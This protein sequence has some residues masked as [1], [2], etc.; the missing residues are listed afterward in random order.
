MLFFLWLPSADL[1]VT[2][3][4]NRVRQGGHNIAEPDIRRRF[5]TGFRNLFGLYRVLVDRW[6]LYDASHYPARLIAQEEGGKVQVAE[7]ALY[8]QIMIAAER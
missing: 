5:S 2:R 7:A 8:N 1:A 6:W 3:V 4:A